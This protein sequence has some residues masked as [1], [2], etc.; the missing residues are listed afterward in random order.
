MSLH[1]SRHRDRIN[2]RDVLKLAGTAASLAAFGT[3]PVVQA[4]APMHGV[5]R[6][7]IYRF[8]LGA[9]EVTNI[10]DGIVQRPPHP[11]FGGNQPAAMIE[12]LAKANGVPGNS[13]EQTYV[14]T[15]VNT[16]R[17]LVLFDT[18]NGRGRNPAVG[19]L[20]ELME[21]AGY[22]PEQIDVV[23]ITTAIRT[24]SAGW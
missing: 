3:V 13:Y 14:N 19:K 9:F 22:K 11:T 20:T 8:K 4:A 15:I 23:V 21:K 5:L 18:G 7:E 6:P 10:L 16:G 12:E 17:E 2:R 1:M 24:T